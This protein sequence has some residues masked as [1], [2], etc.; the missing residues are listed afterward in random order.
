MKYDC[1]KNKIAF[2][3]GSTSGFGKQTAI[4][5]AKNG[6]IVIL[7][8]YNDDKRALKVVEEIS[9]YGIV[10]DCI[11][12]DISKE[13]DILK[14]VNTIKEKYGKLDYLVNN[15]AID[16]GADFENF[17]INDFK[18]EINANLTH[19]FYLIQQCIELLKKS[20]MPRIINVASR[21][22]ERPLAT[23]APLCISE[24]G[25]VML[26]KVAALELAK[27]NIKVNTVSPAL[28]IT[29]LT[30]AI[31]SKED[32]DAYAK[33]NPSG[34]VC[35]P[36]DVANTILFLLSDDADYINGENVNVNGGILLK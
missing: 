3:T 18:T 4:E 23:A 10:G 15:A 7:S 30:E 29:P 25:T 16:I 35:E 1:F 21:Y 34:R 31:M 9:K 27:Y 6:A 36:K 12:A 5:L 26:T 11:K 24:A 22:A 2:I 14:I 17:D 33:V 20:T 8:Y 32:F 13:E 28:A 19:R